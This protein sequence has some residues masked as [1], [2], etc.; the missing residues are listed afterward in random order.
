M[1]AVGIAISI[2][3]TV[4]TEMLALKHITCHF[5]FYDEDIIEIEGVL[6][7]CG[8]R[9][10]T[11]SL[12]FVQFDKCQ[13]EKI[14]DK[15]PALHFMTSKDL[16]ATRAENGTIYVKKNKDKKQVPTNCSEPATSS[17]NEDNHMP[18][19]VFDR[20]RH[21]HQNF[22]DEARNRRHIEL[23]MRLQRNGVHANY[24][25]DHNH[26]VMRD[27]LRNARRQAR[28]RQRNMER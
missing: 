10:K 20:Y 25:V 3:H 17:D 1:R 6:N 21:E 26:A 4:L 7:E 19:E 28:F 5:F 13:V 11:I 18:I 16:I 14:F 8:Q 2:L 24:I 9:L 15:L 12:P 23:R 27:Q 22:I